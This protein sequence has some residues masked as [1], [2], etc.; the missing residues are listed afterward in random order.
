MAAGA[1][2]ACFDFGDHL[3]LTEAAKLEIRQ[4]RSGQ[5][6]VFFANCGDC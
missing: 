2:A 4:V 1:A 6:L 5:D 3:W